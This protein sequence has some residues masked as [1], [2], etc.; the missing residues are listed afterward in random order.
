MDGF[1]VPVNDFNLGLSFQE[2]EQVLGKLRTFLG[3]AGLT[4]LDACLG[5]STAKLEYLAFHKRA[6]LPAP[7]PCDAAQNARNLSFEKYGVKSAAKS[8]F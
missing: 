7:T 2:Y 3:D 8:L 6:Q 4:V 1:W 5:F